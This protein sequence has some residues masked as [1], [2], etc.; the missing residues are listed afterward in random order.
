MFVLNSGLAV[1]AAAEVEI[2]EPWIRA[3]IPGSTVSAA[4]LRIQS[5]IPLTLIEIGVGA[6]MQAEL[7]ETRLDAGIMKMRALAGLQIP[8]GKLVD[9][10]PGGKHIMLTQV[11]QPIHRGDI[12]PLVLLF[13]AADKKRF[14]LVAN[15]VAR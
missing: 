7:H 8:A 13:E 2:T 14:R 6:G 15:A 4:Y 5:R 9:L 11:T 1:A 12:V 3:T 10:I